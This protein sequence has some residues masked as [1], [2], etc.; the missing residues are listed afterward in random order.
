MNDHETRQPTKCSWV[1]KRDNAL[2]L[3]AG[4]WLSLIHI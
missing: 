4:L 1:R 2:Q 3:Q